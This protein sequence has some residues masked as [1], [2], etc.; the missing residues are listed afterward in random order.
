[1]HIPTYSLYVC[2]ALLIVILSYL[3]L[4]KTEFLI[5]HYALVPI[6]PITISSPKIFE[7]CKLSLLLLLN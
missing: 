3:D 7:K 1:M 4:R 6:A 2:K 5:D